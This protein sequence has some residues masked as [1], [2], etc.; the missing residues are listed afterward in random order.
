MVGQLVQQL[1]AD[2]AVDHLL[3]VR[4]VAEHE[5]QV[6][7]VELRHQRS[8]RAD[9]D[10]GD[11]QGAELGLL[12]HLL[13]AA[14]LHRREHLD[15]EAAVGGGLELLAHAHHGFDRRIAE[16]MHVGRLQHHLGL[17]LGL[18]GARATAARTAV[19]LAPRRSMLRR[20]MLCLVM[21]TSF[22]V[23]AGRIDRQIAPP[24]DPDGPVGRLAGRLVLPRYL[25]TARPTWGLAGRIG[26]W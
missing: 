10:A 3:H 14:E 17:C 13:L 25:T 18:A 26:S 2:R 24:A 4:D 8:H 16:R 6:E 21:I 22:D 1:R 23:L 15:R 12:D 5:R 20:S 19:A 11:L 9:R 7:D